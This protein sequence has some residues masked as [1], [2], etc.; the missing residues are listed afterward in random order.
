[1]VD[2]DTNTKR[3]AFIIAALIATFCV[4]CEAVKACQPSQTPSPDPRRNIPAVEQ[5]TTRPGGPVAPTTTGGAGAVV[6]GHN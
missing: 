4:G 5:T 2:I 1:M 6:P 3:L